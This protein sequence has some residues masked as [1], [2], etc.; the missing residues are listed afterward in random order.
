MDP[1]K[2]Q[3]E[4]DYISNPFKL[5]WGATERLFN[6]NKTWAIII[7]VLGIFSSLSSLGNNTGSNNTSDTTG[8][9]ASTANTDV[10]SII[11]VVVVVGVIALII[12][13]LVSVMAVYIQG[14]LTYVALQSEKGKKATLSEATAAVSKRFGL[15]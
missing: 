10:T 9:V 14:I 6:T 8:S 13:A 12:I 2:P 7:L 15:L 1:T 3:K 5:A 4:Q 11:A